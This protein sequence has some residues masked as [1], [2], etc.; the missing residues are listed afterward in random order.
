M[1]VV[2]SRN[3]YGYLH[4]PDIVFPDFTPQNC[5]K[6]GRRLNED[7]LF[8]KVVAISLASVYHQILE[9]AVG[10]MLYPQNLQRTGSY[11][12][13]SAERSRQIF[14]KLTDKVIAKCQGGDWFLDINELPVTDA[15]DRYRLLYTVLCYLYEVRFEYR[16]EFLPVLTPLSLAEEGLF[17]RLRQDDEFW[18]AFR[19]R[20]LQE[21]SQKMRA[22][23]L[24]YFL[25]SESYAEVGRKFRLQPKSAADYVWGFVKEYAKKEFPLTFNSRPTITLEQESDFSRHDFHKWF[26]ARV[27]LEYY[28]MEYRFRG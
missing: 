27:V 25:D 17:Q 26:V 12:E 4:L 10:A 5:Q 11:L 19:E 16:L 6:I 24:R 1:S 22:G 9:F 20:F 2:L 7:L 14:N 13:I 15:K 21:A 18:E 28:Y 23:L 8:Q 3:V